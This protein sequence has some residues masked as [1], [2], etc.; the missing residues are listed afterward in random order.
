[1]S[2]SIYDYS[3]LD[4]CWDALSE[5]EKNNYLARA[6]GNYNLALDIFFDCELNK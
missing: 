3:E 1:M 5:E 4:E 2:N 6:G